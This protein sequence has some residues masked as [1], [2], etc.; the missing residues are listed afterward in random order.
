MQFINLDR[1]YKNIK[2]EIQHAINTVLEHGQYILGPEV[3]E[4][5]IELS[6]RTKS[7]H[8]IGVSSGSDALLIAL[9]A[10]DIRPGDEVITTPFSFIA[11]AEMISVLGAKPVYADVESDTFNLNPQNIEPLITKN[12]K[13]IVA[14]SIFGQCANMD[15]I[16]A[17]AEE[18]NLT[19]IED[20]AQSFGATYKGRSSCALTQIAIT[21]FYPSKPL[22][23]YG[24]GGACFTR[25][26]ELA[27]RMRKIRIHGQDQPYLHSRL[28]INGRLDTIQAAILLTKLKVLTL[29]LEKRRQAAN[30]YT[31]Q[32]N[33]AGFAETPRIEKHNTS[34]YAQ[35]T[36]LVKNRQAVQQILNTKGIPSAVF[37]P[38]PLNRQP[39][40]HNDSTPCPNSDRLSE[41]VLS[42]PLCAYMTKEEQDHVI[43][44]FIEAISETQKTKEPSCS[45]NPT[46]T[47]QHKS[48]QAPL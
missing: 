17:I 21:S 40:T 10:L 23:A 45:L 41:H 44:H 26:D 19:V 14:V 30:Y 15:Q 5:E 27:E 38:V 7:K 37:Y 2:K 13:A 16:N 11:T 4:L 39:A 20:A 22:G 29:D 33:N 34:T 36:V 8:V 35:Y 3:D 25:C 46:H 47:P 42:L 6:R 28:G 1:Q 24:D 9:L 43:N 48:M 32:L 31:Q 12:T 18:Y